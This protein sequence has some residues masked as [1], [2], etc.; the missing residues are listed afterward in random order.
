MKIKLTTGLA[1]AECK[2]PGDPHECDQAEAI[3]MIEAGFA[4]PYD[5]TPAKKEKAVKKPPAETR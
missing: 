4:V 2:A 3:R 5:D 1:G